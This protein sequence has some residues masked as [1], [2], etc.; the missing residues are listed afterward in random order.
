MDVQK[1][2]V[3]KNMH[4]KIT[5]NRNCFDNLDTDEKI[6]FIQCWNINHQIEIVS[7]TLHATVNLVDKSNGIEKLAQITQLV[8]L[9]CQFAGILYE[10]WNSIQNSYYSTKLSQR[11]HDKLSTNTQEELKKLRQYF[12][13]KNFVSELRNKFSFHYDRN[14]IQEGLNILKPTENIEI[15]LPDRNGSSFCAQASTVVSASI[16]NTIC[17][18]DF[19]SA[20]KMLYD[21][22]LHNVHFWIN[23]FCNNYCALIC[24][25]CGVANREPLGIQFEIKLDDLVLPYFTNKDS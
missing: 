14:K 23:D 25:K 15:L 8:F 11:Y 4:T 9:Y 20:L 10:A 24:E 22:L 3:A 13:K 1:L 5:I 2:L 16:L 7:N 17:S 12:A 18:N 19:P 6:L 21:E